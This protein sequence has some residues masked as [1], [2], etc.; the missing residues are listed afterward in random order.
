MLRAE[1]PVQQFSHRPG[2][3][4]AHHHEHPHQPG[5]VGADNEPVPKNE[6]HPSCVYQVVLEGFGV[7]SIFKSVN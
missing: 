4:T 2:H 3:R 1:Q 6:V 5:E 7:C